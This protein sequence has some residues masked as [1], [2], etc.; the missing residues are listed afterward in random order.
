MAWLWA[1]FCISKTVSVK[2]FTV[3]RTPVRK[4]TVFHDHLTTHSD[5]HGG[6][7][8]FL[9]SPEEKKWTDSGPN[10]PHYPAL[11]GIWWQNVAKAIK[12]ELS[13]QQAMDALARQQDE[14]MGKLKLARYSPRL[15][16]LKS[17]E[18]WLN[19]PGSP[20]PERPREAPKTIDYDTLIKHWKK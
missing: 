2:K 17:R 13:P 16:P 15:N 1:Q 8:E 18:Y 9:R 3:G 6:L 4:S 12:G 20:K 7:I 14:M 5:D 11:S 19:Q 10:V